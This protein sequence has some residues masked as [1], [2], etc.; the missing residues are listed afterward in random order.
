[1]KTLF[2]LGMGQGS[3]QGRPCLLPV[4]DVFCHLLLTGARDALL[5]LLEEVD[6]GALGVELTRGEEAV[7]GCPG[8]G[9]GV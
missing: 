8:E 7:E 5:G 2:P 3:A 6:L 1:M 9:V 4:L